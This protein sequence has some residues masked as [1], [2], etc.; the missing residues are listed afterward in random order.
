M[1]PGYL[2]LSL[3]GCVLLAAYVG[4]PA[5]QTVYPTPSPALATPPRLA[6]TWS[7]SLVLALALPEVCYCLVSFRLIKITCR[8]HRGGLGQ[9]ALMVA[10][11]ATLSTT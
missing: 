2:S 5:D 10:T 8:R 4:S 3:L 1:G 6:L 7:L 9:H 11:A